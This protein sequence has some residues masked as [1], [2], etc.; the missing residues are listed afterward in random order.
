MGGT[1]IEDF[2]KS[3]L[4]LQSTLDITGRALT[5]PMLEY[6]FCEHYLI[7]KKECH[8]KSLHYYYKLK[9]RLKR[10]LKVSQILNHT[11]FSDKLLT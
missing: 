10:S 6:L 7:K 9:E 8:N 2:L 11:H 4:H 1:Y 3:H 5:A